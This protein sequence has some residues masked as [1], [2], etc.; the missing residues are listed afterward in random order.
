MAFWGRKEGG[1]GGKTGQEG[2]HHAFLRAIFRSQT[3]LKLECNNYLQEVG[4]RL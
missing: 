1:G 3:S 2:E 4:K